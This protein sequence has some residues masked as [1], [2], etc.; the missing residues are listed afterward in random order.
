MTRQLSVAFLAL[1]CAHM[2]VGDNIGP[3][4]EIGS[5]LI[6]KG[7]LSEYP[8]SPPVVDVKLGGKTYSL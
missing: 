4:G 3:G 6:Y 1:C 8:V 2:A 7:V 5:E